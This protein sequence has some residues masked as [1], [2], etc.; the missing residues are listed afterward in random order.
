MDRERL[1][2][3]L[4]DGLSL[5]QIGVLENRDPST[6]GYW[7]EKYGLAANGKEKYAPKGGIDAC[8]LQ[9]LVDRAFSMN[10][11]AAELD[12]SVST[13]R[14]WLRKHDIRTVG[15]HARRQAALEALENG[16]NAFEFGCRRHGRTTF[17]VSKSGRSRCGRCSSEAVQ[18]RRWTTKETLAD[19]RGGKCAICG[20]RR[21]L[22]ALQFHHVDPKTKRFGI[23]SG[24]VTRGIARAREEARKCVLLCANCHAEVEAGVTPCPRLDDGASSDEE[25]A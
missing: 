8:A 13:V 2:R 17:L 1:E 16:L 10:Q 6:V 5:S 14:Y 24:G 25:S 15:R 21:Y 18:R 7:V 20:Y 3:Y 9:G 4:A 22:G 12:V 23:A 19:E 11:I